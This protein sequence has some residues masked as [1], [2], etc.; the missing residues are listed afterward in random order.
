M[1]YLSLATLLLNLTIF[2]RYTA[3]PAATKYT[4]LCRNS[5]S[6]HLNEQARRPTPME[7]PAPVQPEKIQRVVTRKCR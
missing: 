7:I 3:L 6:Q 4:A 1:Y 2:L 5:K